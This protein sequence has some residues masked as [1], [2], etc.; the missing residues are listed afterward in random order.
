M[1]TSALIAALLA[2][3]PLAAQ[4]AHQHGAGRLGVVG[5]ETS[6][7]GDAQATFTRGVALL[8]SFEFA[9]AIEAFA[10]AARQDPAC[11]I[12]SWGAALA[13]WGNPFAPAIRPA[14]QIQ[15]GLEAVER[16][17]AA[18]AKTARERAY[19]AAVARLFDEAATVD[20]R[21]RVLA[22]RDA[23][24]RVA[25]DYEDDTEASAF[26]ALAVAASADPTDKSYAAQL[27]AG[28]ILE[29]LWAAQPE[30]PGLAHYIIHAYDVPPLAPRALAAARRYGA[31]APDAPH[32]LHMPSH[33]FTRVGS[34]QESVDANVLS[35]AAARRSGSAPEELHAMDYQLYAYL[36][37]AQDTAA[38]GIVDA[39]PAVAGKLDANAVGAAARAGAGAFALAAIPARYALERGAWSEAARLV[40]RET[41]VLH[42]DA[43]T[44]F[45][46]ALG[47]ARSGDPAAARASIGKL[48][49]I[50]RRL[51]D[52]HE[53]Y[54]SEQVAIQALGASAWLAL[55]EGREA[56]ALQA[57]RSAADREDRTEKNVVT[58]GP[59][60][61]AREML[62]EM[63]LQLKRPQDALV[64]FQKT[65]VKE[66][67]RFKAL[68]GVTE[69]ALAA[70]DRA[71][72]R[73]AAEQLLAICVKG[74]D[75]GRPELARARALVKSASQ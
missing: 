43:M 37:M 25:A 33:T 53:S 64:E 22:Y 62:G 5:F 70:G 11:G 38:R 42:A 47:E 14:A 29:K 61:P 2:C 50:S 34:W 71:A 57:M 63:L 32:A 75:P 7:A 8:H 20:Q 28:A 74:D 56:E 39:L 21:T 12:A 59:L 46:R 26:Y 48:E 35:A 36:Q 45:A 3:T 73:R 72:A 68:S 51:A 58:P 4:E 24:A 30:H 9:P 40:P 16:A 65:L 19:I 6:C 13:E 54:W 31:I 52:A 10:A 67:N 69:A 66:P 15:R 17:R 27:Q 1:R 44:W 60:A 18:G 49:D 23:M 55:A 41:T